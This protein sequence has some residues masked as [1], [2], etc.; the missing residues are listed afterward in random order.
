[1]VITPEAWSQSPL[2]SLV[3]RFGAST[4][5]LA[6]SCMRKPTETQR[7]GRRS[8]IASSHR[9]PGT[10]WPESSHS[11]STS[12]RAGSASMVGLKL[13]RLVKTTQPTEMLKQPLLLGANFSKNSGRCVN[14]PES[15]LDREALV[16]HAVDVVPV[17]RAGAQAGHDGEHRFG[18]FVARALLAGGRCLLERGGI[19]LCRGRG[20][21][22]E[23]VGRW[24]RKAACGQREPQRT[25]R[26]EPSYPFRRHGDFITRGA[27]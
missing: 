2:P 18:A 11:I 9:Q 16:L 25:N 3:P 26:A 4:L 14:R 22:G 27:A 6:S 5:A 24:T 20:G 17:D 7:W 19:G 23:G 10:G 15:L 13:G 8:S 21:R 12:G 1:M